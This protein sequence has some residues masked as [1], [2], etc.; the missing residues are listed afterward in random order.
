M[1]LVHAASSGPIKYLRLSHH[2]MLFGP[3]SNQ[4]AS[5]F[6]CTYTYD[7]YTSTHANR[8]ACADPPY[9]AADQTPAARG[10]WSA[11]LIFQADQRVLKDF[12]AEKL[13]R[14][15]AHFEDH[16]IDV[17]L[18][19]FNWFLVVFVESLP[20]DILL[21]LWDAFLYEGTKVSKSPRQQDRHKNQKHS[22]NL[23]PFFLSVHSVFTDFINVFIIRG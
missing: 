19:T 15:A 10:D 6:Y 9:R 7:M 18:I 16:S 20:S 13:P 4:L 1:L 12:L 8:K 21:P 3:V 23:F 5:L 11:L 2:K 22:E 17:S 14:L